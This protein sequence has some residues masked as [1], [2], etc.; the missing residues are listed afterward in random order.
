MTDGIR[1]VNFLFDF[2]IRVDCRLLYKGKENGRDE[3]KVSTI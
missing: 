2:Y 3:E 1:S